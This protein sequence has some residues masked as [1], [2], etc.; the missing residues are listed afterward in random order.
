MF[1]I[2]KGSKFHSL[3]AAIVNDL[4]VSP[5]VAAD[6]FSGGVNNIAL[7]DQRLYLVFCTRLD[8]YEGAMSCSAL[9]VIRMTLNCILYVAGSQYSSFNRG[10]IWQYFD[11]IRMT[12]AAAFCTLWI[13]DVWNEGSPN[14]RLL[15][16][17]IN[18]AG[19]E[20]VNK[21][22]CSIL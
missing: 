4:H 21:S 11:F 13:L 22:F 5:I 7:L 17:I 10:V 3:G 9:K 18:S 12:H 2:S 15:Q 6:F 19:H 20:G 1:L 16:F 14:K 8:M